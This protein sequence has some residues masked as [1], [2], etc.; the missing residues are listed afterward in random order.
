MVTTINRELYM[1][2]RLFMVTIILYLKYK[3]ARNMVTKT[4]ISKK[5]LW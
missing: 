2:S 1:Q 3:F 4:D 5:T